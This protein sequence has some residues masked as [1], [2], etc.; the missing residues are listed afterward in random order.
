MLVFE[1]GLS[2]S[3]V[4]RLRKCN[5]GRELHTRGLRATILNHLIL[6]P[7]TYYLTTRYCCIQQILPLWQQACSVLGFLLI[8]S[9]LYYSAHYLMHTRHLYWMHR[10]HHKFNAIVLPSSA[11][12]VSA[13]EFV[14]AYMSPFL[15]AAWGASCDK[16]SAV[17]AVLL[18]MTF[19]LIIHTPAL[20]EMLANYP[21]MLVS[22]GDHLAHHRQLTCNY[23]AP[24]FNFDKM[25]SYLN[26]TLYAMQKEKAR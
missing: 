17:V 22:P 23:S 5:G 8:E 9:A 26:E 1:F 19:N 20:E 21:C 11:S 4:Q 10:F 3:D 18:V 6:G 25:I 13:P 16:P 12:A 15:A 24:I 2:S 7:I 14:F